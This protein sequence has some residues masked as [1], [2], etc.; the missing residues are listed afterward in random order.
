MNSLGP[1]PFSFA[2]RY[3]NSGDLVIDKLKNS[4]AQR[5][6]RVYFFLVSRLSAVS[7]A[8]SMTRMVSS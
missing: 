6:E 7:D 2:R 4:R 3:T 8:T 5:L 1:A